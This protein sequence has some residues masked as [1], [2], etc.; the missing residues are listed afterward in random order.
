MGDVMKVFVSQPMRGK[1]K[2]EIEA[3]RKAAIEKFNEQ[4]PDN[5]YE[6]IDSV[7][8]V[9]DDYPPLYWLSQSLQLLSTADLILMMPD[10]TKTRGCV[11]E[12]LC[13]SRYSITVCNQ[14]D[15]VDAQDC[16]DALL[17]AI[18]VDAQNAP[19]LNALIKTD[20]KAAVQ[21]LSQCCAVMGKTNAPVLGENNVYEAVGS[22]FD[23]LNEN[24]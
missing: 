1:N 6:I 9:N 24:L 13:A 5:E 3:A 10:W 15:N 21:I 14:D 22:L 20:K 11:I 18:C 8:D 4:F 23:E 19:D 17:N 2:E 12:Y 16:V 7:L